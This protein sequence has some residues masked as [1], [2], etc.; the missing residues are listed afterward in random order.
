MRWAL[1]LQ[2]Y[3]FEPEYIKGDTNTADWLSRVNNISEIATIKPVYVANPLLRNEIIQEYHEKTGHG[4]V[5]T[6]KVSS[7]KEI[8]LGT[9]KYSN[10]KVH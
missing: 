8:H 4:S 10:R 1:K 2:E 9:N 7:K 6:V 5:N 3:S